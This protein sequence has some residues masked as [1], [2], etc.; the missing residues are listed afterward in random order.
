M[1]SYSKG[2]AVVLSILQIWDCP[3]YFV[4]QGNPQYTTTCVKH[5]GLSSGPFC[6][7]QSACVALRKLHP[8]AWGGWKNT[9]SGEQFYRAIHQ[10]EYSWG[11][12][13][14]LVYIFLKTCNQRTLRVDWRGQSA[15]DCFPWKMLRDNLDTLGLGLVFFQRPTNCPHGCDVSWSFTSG[16]YP[17]AS[18][19]PFRETNMWQ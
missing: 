19:F 5:D 1:W 16:G 11:W 3:N 17:E 9:V 6:L 8:T 15:M 18:C 2:R 14:G 12:G 10:N 13:L 7:F 4:C